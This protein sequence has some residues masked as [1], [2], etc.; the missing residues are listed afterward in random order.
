MIKQMTYGKPIKLI[1]SFTIPVLIGNI[2]QQIYSM[3]D[4][5]VV[6]QFVGIKALA[7]VGVAASL[8]FMILGFIFGLCNGF[9]VVLAQKFGAEDKKGVRKSVT[10][11]IYLC[12]FFTIVITLISMLTAQPLLKLINTPDDVISYATDFILIIYAGIFSQMAY[13]FSAGILRALG[14]SKTSLYFLIIASIINLI[15]DLTTVVIFNMGVVGAAVS[16]VISQIISSVLCIIYMFKKFNIIIPKKEDWKIDFSYAWLHT[17]IGLP[18]GFQYSITAVGFLIL[19]SAINK[20]GSNTV[21]GFTAAVKIEN[22]VIAAFQALSAAV[23]TY[24]AQNFGAR[25][26]HRIKQGARSSALIGLLMCAIFGVLLFIFWKQMVC[27]F[28]GDGQPEVTETARQYL[29]IAIPNY[30]ILCFLL[31]FRNLIQSIGKTIIPLFA[32]A[33]EVIMRAMGAIILA[34]LFG[35][36]GI[37]WSPICAWYAAFILII[38]FYLYYIKNI[39]QLQ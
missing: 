9:C 22:I 34:N 10:T 25:Y 8:T 36:I 35:Y 12:L 28:V 32:G 37:C 21:A 39:K 38:I 3:V 24:T 15:L 26:Y 29:V 31:I 18:M 19:Q 23:S 16:T 2:F 20:L 33:S 7:G 4:T 13:N 14:D 27:L 6:G 5:I 11:S 30:P 1:T 17:K